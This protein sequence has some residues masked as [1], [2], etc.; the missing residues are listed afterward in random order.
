[1]LFYARA[2]RNLSFRFLRE[3]SSSVKW[4]TLSVLKSVKSLVLTHSLLYTL[5]TESVI[6]HYEHYS[7]AQWAPTWLLDVRVLP[8]RAESVGAAVAQGVALKR[9]YA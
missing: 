6:Y 2:S 7:P 3:L 8:R 1:M 5:K 4:R 9:R